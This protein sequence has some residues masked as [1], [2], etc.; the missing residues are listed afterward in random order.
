M[1]SSYI[2]KH[3][4]VRNH[5]SDAIS[6]SNRKPSKSDILSAIQ[7]S[8]PLPSELYRNAWLKYNESS[9][10]VWIPSEIVKIEDGYFYCRTIL[11][12]RMTIKVEF[13]AANDRRSDDT[14]YPMNEETIYTYVLCLSLSTLSFLLKTFIT[15]LE[16]LSS[17]KY[18]QRLRLH[19]FRSAWAKIFLTRLCPHL[20]AVNYK[21]VQS[22]I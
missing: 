5:Y 16:N 1:S 14:L 12:P 10:P 6:W 7:R 18:L 13:E 19:F 3:V 8:S 17:V 4:W 22:W 9:P 11:S 2:G 21:F 20:V 15:Q